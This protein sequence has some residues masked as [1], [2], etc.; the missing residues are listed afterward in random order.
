MRISKKHRFIFFSNPKTGSECVRELLD[1][2]SDVRGVSFRDATPQFPY[3]SHMRPVEL[4]AVMENTVASFDDYYRFTFVRNPWARLVSLYKMLLLAEPDFP[5]LFTEWLP[6]IRAD[7]PGGGG[8]GAQPWRQYGAYTLQAFAG[9]GEGRLLVHDVFRLEDIGEVVGHLR[10]R[11]FIEDDG[12]AIP[13]INASSNRTPFRD[14]YD[15]AARDLVAE[16]YREDI[17][18]FSYSFDDPA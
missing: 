11:G 3:H 4:R 8:G 15:A 5:L 10:A 13:M 16:R 17:E 6:T 1:P 9:D 18:T 14:Y 2:V 12:A 7:G